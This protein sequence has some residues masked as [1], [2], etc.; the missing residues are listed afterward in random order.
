MN[1][2]I[3]HKGPEDL[4]KLKNLGREIMKIIQRRKPNEYFG[5]L[6]RNM[7]AEGMVV[8]VRIAEI[9]LYNLF[10][11]TPKQRATDIS[12]PSKP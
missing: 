9:I 11:R 5:S 2:H 12:A 7:T 8:V 10:E 3:D 4:A 1:S 6:S